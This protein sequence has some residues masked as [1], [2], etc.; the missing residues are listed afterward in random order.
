[1]PATGR[2]AAHEAHRVFLV[3]GLAARLCRE[4]V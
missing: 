1:M 2:R 4:I 3:L